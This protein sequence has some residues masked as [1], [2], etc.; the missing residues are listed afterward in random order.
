MGSASEI[1]K[2]ALTLKPVE[3]AEV[4]DKLL[5]SLDHPDSEIDQLWAAE[6]ESRIDAYEQGRIKAISLE[7]VL[8][9]YK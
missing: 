3:K 2:A 7:Q 4:V 5:R 9:R 6:A 1:L 8:A